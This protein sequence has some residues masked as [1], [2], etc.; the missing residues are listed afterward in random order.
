MCE[1]DRSECLLEAVEGE[2]RDTYRIVIVGRGNWRASPLLA[3]LGFGVG[4]CRSLRDSECDLL[5]WLLCVDDCA[6]RSEVSE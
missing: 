3:R 2:G 5:L 1:W 4:E 6:R